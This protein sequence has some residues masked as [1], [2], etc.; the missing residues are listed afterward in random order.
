MKL[1]GMGNVN[2][3]PIEYYASPH[4][5]QCWR[6]LRAHAYQS[7]RQEAI[8]TRYGRRLVFALRYVAH[9]RPTICGG[10]ALLYNS[11]AI[12]MLLSQLARR[13]ILYQMSARPCHKAKMLER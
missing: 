6:H 8:F 10:R 7:P 9:H 2:S 11:P 1:N 13:A 12:S 3:K 5:K 4:A